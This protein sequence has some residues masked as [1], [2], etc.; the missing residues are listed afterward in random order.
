MA[1]E[2]ADPAR[3]GAYQGLSQTGLALALMLG[4][5][6]VTTT[7]IDHGTLGW[8]ALGTLFAL[9]GTAIAIVANR[10]AASRSRPVDVPAAK[11]PSGSVDG[12]SDVALHAAEDDA[13]EGLDR[14][15]VEVAGQAVRVEQGALPEDGVAGR[16]L[17]DDQL[18]P[19][20]TR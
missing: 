4:P 10:A 11:L 7:A 20:Q 18:E 1:F 19:G 5:A 12:V 16:V 9:A 17:V 15:P 3:A 2:L 14:P 8:I 13:V 6:A